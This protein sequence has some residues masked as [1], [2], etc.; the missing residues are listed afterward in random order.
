MKETKTVYILYGYING[1]FITEMH[2][3]L[4]TAKAIKHDYMCFRTR[5]ENTWIN[6]KECIDNGDIDTE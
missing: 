5:N 1:H 6:I 4:Y 3:S 2:N